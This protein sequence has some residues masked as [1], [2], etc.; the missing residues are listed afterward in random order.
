MTS[1]APTHVKTA[2][3]VVF[4]EAPLRTVTIIIPM[5]TLDQIQKQDTILTSKAPLV[6]NGVDYGF[7]ETGFLLDADQAACK[8]VVCSRTA[9]KGLLGAIT[10]DLDL[11]VKSVPVSDPT[12]PPILRSV[13][14]QFSMGPVPTTVFKSP[15]KYPTLKLILGFRESPHPN[16]SSD[17]L[18]LYRSQDN[19]DITFSFGS[20]ELK[21]HKSILGARSVYFRQMFSAGMKENQ[22]GVIEIDDFDPDTFEEALIFLYTGVTSKFL[23]RK[24]A[25]SLLPLADKYLIESLKMACL[26]QIKS[27]LNVVNVS[28]VLRLAMELNCTPL[29]D[30]CFGV[31]KNDMTESKRWEILVEIGDRDLSSEFLKTIDVKKAEDAEK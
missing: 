10:G 19:A 2:P 6:S 9:F 29:R 18:Q 23:D 25:M 24:L 26:D 7:L 16:L 11:S 21:A 12:L 20:K 13:E 22:T 14:G 3:I 15:T 1:S 5:P 27:N 4:S 8:L 31:M 17:L 28:E 30:A